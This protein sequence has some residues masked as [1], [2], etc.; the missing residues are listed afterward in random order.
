MI[1]RSENAKRLGVDEMSDV[2]GEQSRIEFNGDTGKFEFRTTITGPRG[3]THSTLY[4]WDPDGVEWR[5][6]TQGIEGAE[7][8]FYQYEA[9]MQS[10][11]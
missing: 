8:E 3:V 9:K 11:T 7:E 2:R 10:S 5:R 4:D 6:F 1:L